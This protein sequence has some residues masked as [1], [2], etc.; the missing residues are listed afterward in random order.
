MKMTDFTELL[1][2]TNPCEEGWKWYLKVSKNH[3]TTTTKL[4][5]FF[6]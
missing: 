5:R 3:K 2:T 6:L 1:K 4:E